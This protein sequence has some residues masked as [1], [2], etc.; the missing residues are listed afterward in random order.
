MK[1]FSR[2]QKWENPGYRN[3]KDFYTKNYPT[4][5]AADMLYDNTTF[6]GLLWTIVKGNDVYK[7]MGVGDSIVR[8]RLFSR[9]AQFLNKDYNYVYKIWMDGLYG[10]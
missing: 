9:L 3:L 6:G 4:D 7:Y 2:F 1:D 10:R 5:G 8:E